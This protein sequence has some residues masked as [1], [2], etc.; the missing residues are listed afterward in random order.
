MDGLDI[1][2]GVRFERAEMSFHV[3]NV[4]PELAMRWL[5]RNHEKN[6]KVRAVTVKRFAHDMSAGNWPLTHQP[7][8][9]DIDGRLIDGQHRLEAIIS[10]QASARMVIAC[11]VPHKAM[12]ALDQGTLRTPVDQARIVDLTGIRTL[13]CAIARRLHI[14]NVPATPCPPTRADVLSTMQ[15][16]WTKITEVLGYSVPYVPRVTTASVLAVF[17]RAAYTHSSAVLSRA[18]YILRTGETREEHRR[19]GDRTLMQLRTWLLTGLVKPSKSGGHMRQ[20][21]EYRKTERALSAYLSGEDVTKI[22]EEEEEL[23][24]LPQDT[25]DEHD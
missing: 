24:P 1:F 18:L 3:V 5:E 9:F 4:T 8:A 25:D 20:L 17:I 21:S 13:H 2:T 19:P 14:G 6:R 10:S 11:N 23:F 16:H 12:I 7:V 15:V 22:F